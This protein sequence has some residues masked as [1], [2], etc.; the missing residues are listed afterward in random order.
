MY[1]YNLILMILSFTLVFPIFVQVL[2]HVLL[3]L[4]KTNK[5]TCI[6]LSHLP[7]CKILLWTRLCLGYICIFL[8]LIE[9]TL[10]LEVC[11]NLIFMIFMFLIK[12]FH[13]YFE[14][15]WLFHEYNIH[16]ILMHSHYFRLLIYLFYEHI[17]E[18]FRSV[19]YTHLTLPTIYSV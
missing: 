8:V 11:L 2:L 16:I 10:Y 7:S 6:P 17:F 15:Y 18:P 1:M 3:F 19:S 4:S 9:H 14:P 5:Y 13:V 12:E